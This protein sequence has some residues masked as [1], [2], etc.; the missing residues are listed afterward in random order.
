MYYI[1]SDHLGSIN[2]IVGGSNGNVVDDLSY[3]A[4][5]R[6]RN[7]VDWSYS[8]F[9]LSS[10]TD[11]GYTSHEQL[12]NFGLINM[13]GRIY[14]PMTL[15]FLSPDPF[16]QNPANSQNYNRFSYVLNNPL[17]YV[18]PS[19]YNYIDWTYAYG[20]GNGE[21]RH[22]KQELDYIYNRGEYSL[23]GG[24]GGLGKFYYVNGKGYQ[25][26]SSG[27]II[28]TNKNDQGTNAFYRGDDFGFY[29]QTSG[30]RI[31][32]TKNGRTVGVTTSDARCV[33]VSAGDPLPAWNDRGWRLYGMGYDAPGQRKYSNF[34]SDGVWTFGAT[35]TVAASLV[36][37]SLET[38]VTL[39]F[40]KG[41]KMG[42]YL[43]LEHAIGADI[44]A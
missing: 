39:D 2:L 30:S 3:D 31:Y 22:W 19:G 5:G 37:V 9:T 24:F 23:G 14:D 25:I 12:P 16:V 34:F 27:S 44:S 29:A 32:A 10:I 1:S 20:T 13:N 35:G 38:G 42:L 11:R 15:G 28:S 6:N 33:W 17:K 8:N 41:F 36:G 40:R 18:D 21:P 43:T 7:P 26:T 4:W